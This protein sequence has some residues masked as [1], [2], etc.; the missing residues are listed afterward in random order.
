MNAIER[1]GG[2]PLGHLLEVLG[3]SPRHQRSAMVLL[4]RA[5]RHGWPIP[6]SIRR[7]A[8]ASCAR[9]MADESAGPRHRLRAAE[10]LTA[11]ARQGNAAA[12]HAG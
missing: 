11:M 8:P 2:E 3:G 1:E 4:L 7:H 6:A 12:A 5:I 9:I 10:V